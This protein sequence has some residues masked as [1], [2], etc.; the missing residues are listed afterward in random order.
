MFWFNKQ[1][2]HIIKHVSCCRDS[3]CCRALFSQAAHGKDDQRTAVQQCACRH[4]TLL[5][6]FICLLFCLSM[7]ATQADQTTHVHKCAYHTYGA[8]LLCAKRVFAVS[9]YSDWP[10]ETSAHGIGCCAFSHCIQY[11]LVL[12]LQLHS[13]C[14]HSSGLTRC[15]SCPGHRCEGDGA[16]SAQC[17]FDSRCTI[18]GAE[19]AAGSTASTG[20]AHQL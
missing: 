14:V 15:E 20:T 13:L 7:L 3:L 1:N 12:P 17:S 9:V 19:V 8:F 4:T 18:K 11:I 16:G 10:L 2:C 5:E 6:L